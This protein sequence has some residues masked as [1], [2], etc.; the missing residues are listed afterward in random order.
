M[1]RIGNFK[2]IIQLEAQS[3]MIHFQ[4]SQTGATLRA[5]EVKPKLDRFLCQK[6]QIGGKKIPDKWK[7]KVEGNENI[8]LNYKMT[9]ED[10][11]ATWIKDPKDRNSRKQYP[12][13]YAGSADILWTN[14]KLT[15][16]CKDSELLDLIQASIAE[17]F[18]VTNF[19]TMQNKGF[20]S[21]LVEREFKDNL[22]QEDIEK[23]AKYFKDHI[24]GS[25]VYYMK[26]LDSWQKNPKKIMTFNWIKNFHRLLKSGDNPRHGQ[27]IKSYLFQYM[28]T[29][30]IENEKAVLKSM[31]IAP[32]VI[33]KE[34][35]VQSTHGLTEGRERF[36]RALLG[37]PGA[38]SFLEKPNNFRDR[39]KIS[40]RQNGDE[41]E[42]ERMASPLFYKIIKDVLFICPF[43]IPDAIFDKDFL[44]I[45][46]ASRCTIK[47]PSTME[48][49]LAMF[50]HTYASKA[51]P[52]IKSVIV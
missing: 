41:K 1:E 35:V 5:T 48:F 33:N 17:F 36:T 15:I 46:D 42:I 2:L 47:T 34:G 37:L 13:F 49:D 52:R 4:G 10:S 6:Y 25:E 20:G 21:F 19:G 29:K 28:F 32:S 12:I 38:Y 23:V 45:R 26:G 11:E 7:L 22:S 18:C 39:V 43:K 27:Y 40:I 9:L 3:P 31:G 16:F 30:N 51:E 50:M 8:A 24:A 44:F 14:P